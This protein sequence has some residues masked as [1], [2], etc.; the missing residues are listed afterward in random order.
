[1]IELDFVYSV[2]CRS[3]KLSKTK[4]KKRERI[5]IF[6]CQ[7]DIQP[8]ESLTSISLK[9]NVHVAELKRVNNLLT[10]NEFFALKRIKIPVKPS[11][12]LTELLPN[13]TQGN[14]D[15]SGWIIRRATTPDVSGTGCTSSTVPST[16]NSETEGI[17]GLDDEV[18]LA[19]LHHSHQHHSP[20]QGGNSSKNVK[21]AKYFL[22]NVDKDLKR[23]REKQV[24]FVL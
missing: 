2:K 4:L 8:G 18:N 19:P 24:I 12:L 17:G 14:N 7:V 11:S 20:V 3:L 15:G 22:K 16:P 21:K 5:N 6:G 9:Y 13:Q 23:I 10:E 1:M